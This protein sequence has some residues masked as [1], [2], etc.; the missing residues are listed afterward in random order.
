MLDGKCQK[1][2]NLSTGQCIIQIAKS[3]STSYCLDSSKSQ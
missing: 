1:G 2:V 3:V